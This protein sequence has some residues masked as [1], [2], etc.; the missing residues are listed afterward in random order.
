M[1]FIGSV[2]IYS[3]KIL[4]ILL[5]RSSKVLTEPACR[6]GGK[7]TGLDENG[8]YTLVLVR[9][10]EIVD[11]QRTHFHIMYNRNFLSRS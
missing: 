11:C 9:H 10:G 7:E 8:H 5:N 6:G 2:L 4:F 3:K 1:L